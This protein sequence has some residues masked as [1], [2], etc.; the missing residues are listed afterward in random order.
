MP[1]S[2]EVVEFN[3]QLEGEPELINTNPYGKRVDYANE[4]LKTLSQLDALLDA[5]A[6]GEL[7]GA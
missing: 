1:I 7:I 4:K 2:G 6:Y 3:T 5:A